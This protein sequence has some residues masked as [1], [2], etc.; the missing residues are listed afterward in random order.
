MTFEQWTAMESFYYYDFVYLMVVLVLSAIALT[1][2]IAHVRQKTPRII[3]II[4]VII[5]VVVGTYTYKNYQHHQ[6]VIDQTR[7]VN[8]AIREYEQDFLRKRSIGFFEKNQYRTGYLKD[9]FEAVGLYEPEMITSP[10][11]YLGDDGNYHYFDLD[12]LIVYTSNRYVE[13]SD[14]VQESI[15]TGTQYHLK[16]PRFTK[17]GFYESSGHFF[18]NYVVPTLEK[19]KK[20]TEEIEEVAEYQGLLDSLRGWILP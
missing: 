3:A 19:G 8:A 13:F 4:S 2:T 12:G 5:L 1:A 14:T 6:P 7:Y 11:N 10:V 9:Y 15:R 16:D 17:I 20:I 18:D